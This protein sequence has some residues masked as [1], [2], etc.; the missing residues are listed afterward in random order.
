M[1]ARRAEGVPELHITGAA[2]Q[3]LGHLV[4]TEPGALGSD[5]ML[6]ALARIGRA[7]W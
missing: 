7:R 3:F 2:D 4:T 5:S 1:M 6:M